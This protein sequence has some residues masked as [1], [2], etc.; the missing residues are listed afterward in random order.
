M[1]QLNTVNKLAYGFSGILF[2]Q[3]ITVGWVHGHT[4]CHIGG[5]DPIHVIPY[6][7]TPD[8]GDPF[9]GFVMHTVVFQFHQQQFQN[10]LTCITVGS[11]THVPFKIIFLEQ[12]D[13]CMLTFIYQRDNDRRR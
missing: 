2:I 1:F 12:T 4:S 13:Q 11:V 8:T 3:S 10:E 9:I 5:M 6:H 7:I